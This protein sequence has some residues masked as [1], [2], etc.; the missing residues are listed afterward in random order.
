[1]AF[2]NSS[3]NGWVGILHRQ[4]GCLHSHHQLTHYMPGLFSSNQDDL[5]VLENVVENECKQRDRV[6]LQ[7]ISPNKGIIGM[8]RVKIPSKLDLPLLSQIA[9]FPEVAYL[10]RA[11]KGSHI[12]P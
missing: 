4:Q 5:A 12:V 6:H 11:Y 10:S 2:G 8:N 3:K 7:R 9:I 1:M